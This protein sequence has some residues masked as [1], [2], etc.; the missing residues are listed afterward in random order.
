[1]GAVPNL[2]QKVKHCLAPLDG[3]DC[4]AERASGPM[5][6]EV[7][8]PSN[9]G[10]TWDIAVI[11]TCVYMYIYMFMRYPQISQNYGPVLVI[12]YFTI[13]NI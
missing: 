6:E 9:L 10:F 8:I 11:H 3:S 7:G 13:R 4:F 12:D 5:L 1:M 2:N